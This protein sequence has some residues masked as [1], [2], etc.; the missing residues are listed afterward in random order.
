[1]KKNKILIVIFLFIGIISASNNIDSDGDGYLDIQ[2]IKAGT[3]PNDAYSIIYQGFWPFNIN[4]DKIEDPGFGECPKANGCECQTSKTCPEDSE[5]AQLNRGKFCIP[6]VGSR[7]PRFMGVDQFGD[8]F[9]LYD[10]ANQGKP[11]IIE[12]GT[13]WP[14][15]CKDFSAWK[16]Y[17]NDNVLSAKWWKNEYASI[18]NYIDN[19][20]IYWVHIIHLDDD[21][22]PSTFETINSWYWDYPHDNIIYLADPAAKMK[23]WVRPTAYPCLILIDE[24]MDMQVHALRGVEDAIYEVYNRLEEKVGK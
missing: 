5:C 14:K 16:T 13:T 23:T 15:A 1:M 10:L 17:V 6:K 11:I 8:L 2:E 21:R 4:K 18:R 12:I 24:N 7:V 3:D 22:N 9:D 19:G 20:D